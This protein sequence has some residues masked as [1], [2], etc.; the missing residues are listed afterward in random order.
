MTFELR[1]T[2]MHSMLSSH[3]WQRGVDHW[4]SSFNTG[5]IGMPEYGYGVS[6]L[7]LVVPEYRCQQKSCIAVTSFMMWIPLVTVICFPELPV[8]IVG[9]MY[10]LCKFSI[11]PRSSNSSYAM[12]SVSN[13]DVDLSLV[14]WLVRA[15]SVARCLW[16]ILQYC[17]D[18]SEM[19]FLSAENLLS[20]LHSQL[21][22]KCLTVV[23]IDK[24]G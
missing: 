21:S 8:T 12:P 11:F 7:V 23:F 1:N 14:S 4:H 2:F 6:L 9:Y 13:R 17:T 18:G 24:A 22:N 16:A 15:V 19:T 10:M 3:M 5:I 20:H